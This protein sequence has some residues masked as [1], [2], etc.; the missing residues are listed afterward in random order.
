MEAVGSSALFMR[1]ATQGFESSKYHKESWISR[2][3]LLGNIH[4]VTDREIDRQIGQSTNCQIN[5][6]NALDARICSP[7]HS[8]RRCFASP[9]WRH[10]KLVSKF[11]MG[12]GRE[13]TLLAKV[14]Q[15]LSSW[16]PDF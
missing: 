9:R 4:E 8:K 12:N 11:R 5:D 14:H 1:R 13:A 6:F 7:E 3:Y 10:F 2:L 15:G 16:G